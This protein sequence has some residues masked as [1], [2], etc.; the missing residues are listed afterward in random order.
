MAYSKINLPKIDNSFLKL[1]NLDLVSYDIIEKVYENQ[2]YF[3]RN[4]LIINSM[5]GLDVDVYNGKYLVSIDIKENMVGHKLGE[6][7]ITKVLGK[8][9]GRNRNKKKKKGLRKKKA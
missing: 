2:K 7:S 3:S 4:T 6:S 9:T 1:T 5:V 8:Y